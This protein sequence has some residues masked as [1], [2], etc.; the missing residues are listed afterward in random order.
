MT[1]ANW[2]DESPPS[3]HFQYTGEMTLRRGD[4]FG[5]ASDIRI[6]VAGSIECAEKRCRDT[7]F[8]TLPAIFVR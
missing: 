2:L 5:A 7:V 4:F 6:A 8:Q 3:P 1:E